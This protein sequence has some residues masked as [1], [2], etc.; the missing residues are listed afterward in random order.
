[1]C[2][3]CMLNWKFVYFSDLSSSRNVVT[4]YDIA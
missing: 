2:D 3:V 4:V 1:M